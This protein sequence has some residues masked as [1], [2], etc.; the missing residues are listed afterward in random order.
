MTDQRHRRGRDVDD[1]EPVFVI[2]VA[3]D[4]V[5]AHPQTLRGYERAGLVVPARTPGGT[6]RYSRDDLRRMQRIQALTEEGLTLAG[7]RRVLELEDR[8]EALA[9][10]TRRPSTA[11]VLRRNADPFS[12]RTLTVSPLR[13][14]REHRTSPR[15]PLATDP[16]RG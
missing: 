11:L 8:L 6:R 15:P 13:A 5:G 1:D 3:A 4:L 9:E 14:G 12:R 10:A 2:S 7:V 16:S